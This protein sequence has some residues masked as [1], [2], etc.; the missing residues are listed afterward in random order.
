MVVTVKYVWRR[1]RIYMK[2]STIKELRELCMKQRH[3]VSV[4]FNKGIYKN[5]SWFSEEQ[6][7]ST[8]TRCSG[9]EILM[10]SVLGHDSAL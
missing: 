7:D 5:C 3:K 10:N 9:G 2:L 4:G 1:K 8:F 6:N